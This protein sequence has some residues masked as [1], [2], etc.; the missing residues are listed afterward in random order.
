MSDKSVYVYYAD[1]SGSMQ[2]PNYEIGYQDLIKDLAFVQ[3]RF[4][5]NYSEKYKSMLMQTAVQVFLQLEREGIKNNVKSDYDLLIE[6]DEGGLFDLVSYYYDQRIKESK[7]TILVAIGQRLIRNYE[8][9]AEKKIR[10]DVNELVRVMT[11]GGQYCGRTF[12]EDYF[13]EL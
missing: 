3:L 9:Y 7:E 8:I 12:T 2:V 6:H 13:D 5:N 10:A 4:A 11:E 1:G